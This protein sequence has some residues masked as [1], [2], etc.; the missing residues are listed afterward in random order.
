MS[1]L[2]ELVRARFARHK[3]EEVFEAAR[4][5]AGLGHYEVRGWVGWHH[6]ITLSLLALWFLCCERR[7]VG[8]E[9]PG[10]HRVA[11]PGSL[12]QAVAGPLPGPRADRRG[13]HAGAT[14]EGGGPD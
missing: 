7:R 6:H 10:D 12:H 5:E 4:Q 2:G 13:G 14:A 1:P 3:I 8:G 11:G 9:N